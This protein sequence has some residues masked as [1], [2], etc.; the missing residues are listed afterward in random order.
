MSRWII[1]YHGVFGFFKAFDRVKRSLLFQVLTLYG[2]P[3]MLVRAVSLLYEERTVAIRL[4]KSSRIHCLT[5]MAPSK[6]KRYPPFF[7]PFS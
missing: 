7:L 1:I 3:D 4:R 5:I 2:I 6:A